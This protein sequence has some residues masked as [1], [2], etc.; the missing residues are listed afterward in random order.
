MKVIIEGEACFNGGKGDDSHEVPVE[1]V[2]PPSEDLK[3][4]EILIVH[5][6]VSIKFSRRELQRALRAFEPGRRET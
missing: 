1:I 4:G 5:P 2:G 3:A 6:R